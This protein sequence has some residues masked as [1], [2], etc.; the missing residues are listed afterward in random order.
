MTDFN[1]RR[2]YE[3]LRWPIKNMKRLKGRP[4]RVVFDDSRALT[5]ALRELCA[6]DVRPIEVLDIDLHRWGH[7]F[8]DPSRVRAVLRDLNLPAYGPEIR[9]LP[10]RDSALW[11]IERLTTP[12]EELA[13]C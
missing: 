3:T 11:L 2:D 4:V 6:A 9:W 5:A 1:I 7:L 12:A 13:A 8:Y 10:S